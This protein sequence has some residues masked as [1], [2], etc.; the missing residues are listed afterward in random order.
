MGL[1]LVKQALF[2]LLVMR[3]YDEKKISKADLNHPFAIAI[4]IAV[5]RNKPRQKSHI[6]FC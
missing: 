4:T 6:M 5:I 3:C 1:I 2:S